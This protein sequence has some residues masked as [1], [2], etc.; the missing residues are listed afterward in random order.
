[1]RGRQNHGHVL[2]GLLATMAKAIGDAKPSAE[3]AKVRE[4][5]RGECRDDDEKEAPAA[6]VE[7]ERV[8]TS[9]VMTAANTVASGRCCRRCRLDA[10]D[11]RRGRTRRTEGPSFLK[12]Y[13]YRKA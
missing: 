2:A 13:V 1:M 11:G 7:K 8:A 12:K 4:A 3:P 10:S 5:R 9:T 6:E